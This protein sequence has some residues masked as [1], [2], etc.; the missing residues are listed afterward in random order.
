M[1]ICIALGSGSTEGAQQ[2]SQAQAQ[3]RPVWIS[4]SD[5]GERF[6]LT[7]EFTFHIIQSLKESISLQMV[8]H[9]M[10]DLWD[11]IMEY[12]WGKLLF[13]CLFYG[14][15]WGFYAYVSHLEATGQ[16]GRAP[17]YIA[18]IYNLTGKWFTVILIA[19]PGM[20]LTYVAIAEF[21]D[22]FRN[23]EE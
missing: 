8:E 13:A 16:S 19:I 14:L 17:W 21:I 5:I 2:D 18:I 7:N 10:S 23:D 20:M 11:K 9:A 15:V 6:V 3:P 4:E 1:R 22:M 12:W